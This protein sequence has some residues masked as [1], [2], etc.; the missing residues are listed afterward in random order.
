MKALCSYCNEKH[1]VRLACPEYINRNLDLGKNQI[2][3]K[4]RVSTAALYR[5]DLPHP[6]WLI[7]TWIFS[8][9][10]RQKSHQVVHGTPSAMGAVNYYDVMYARKIHKIITNNLR[11]RHGGWRAVF[12]RHM[13]E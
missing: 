13:W 9:D 1:D 8:D 4:I 12:Y 10:P 5:D 7:E 3:E 6:Y 2:T 11:N